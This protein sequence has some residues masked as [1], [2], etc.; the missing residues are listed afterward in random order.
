MSAIETL[1]FVPIDEIQ[2]IFI[3][4]AHKTE[5]YIKLNG[6]PRNEKD[7][8]DIL[9]EYRSQL[10]RR[11][12]TNLANYLKNNPQV[13]QEIREERE[14]K[15]LESSRM[16]YQERREKAKEKALKYKDSYPES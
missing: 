11:A 14:A 3:T 4:V 7:V 9:D 5:E 1:G 2:N 8:I 10:M 13:K 12:K 15:T 6:M 16:T